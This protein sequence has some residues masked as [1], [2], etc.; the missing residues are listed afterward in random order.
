MH[1]CDESLYTDPCGQLPGP[2]H[3][4]GEQGAECKRHREYKM[5]LLD[6][7]NNGTS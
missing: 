1:D 5:T 2:V 6:V 4:T 3:K 7:F